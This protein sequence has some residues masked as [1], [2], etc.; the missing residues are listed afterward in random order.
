MTK[1]EFIESVRLEG[2]E[3]REILGFNNKYYVSNLG[4]VL[5]V[6]T[7][8]LRDGSLYYLPGRIKTKKLCGKHNHMYYYVSFTTGHRKQKNFSIHRLVATAFVDNPLN[9]PCVDHIDG[10][11]LNNISSNLRWVDYKENANNNITYKKQLNKVSRP[12]IAIK[13][14]KICLRYN[15]MADAIKDGFNDCRIRICFKNPTYTHRGYNWTRESDYYT[16][17]SMSKNS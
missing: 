15:N 4:R 1:E 3:W 5:S 7:Y 13:D 16:L 6:P 8:V 12:F 2:E 17:V 14:N 11:Q 10:N 9:K